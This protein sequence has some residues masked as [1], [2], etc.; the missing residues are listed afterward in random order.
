MDRRTHAAAALAASAIWLLVVG[1]AAE[2]GGATWVFED[3]GLIREAIFT[4][5]DRVKA[6]TSLALRAVVSGEKRGAHWAGPEQGPFFAYLSRHPAPGR[7]PQA[8]PLPDTAIFVGEVT[9]SETQQRGILDASLDFVMPDVEPGYYMLH[10]CNDPCTR[11]IGDMMSTPVTVVENR[12]QALLAGRVQRL[13]RRDMA[14]RFRVED[15]ID[16]LESEN[17]ELELQL[18]A[19]RGEVNTPSKEPA[20]AAPAR[21]S[22]MWAGV[23]W[24]LPGAIVAS[25]ALLA[26]G[27]ARREQRA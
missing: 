12:G 23:G 11:Q 16:D 5:G 8:P 19:L 25:L 13:E 9:F 26:F 22:S 18:K 7:R 2:A 1:G 20:E 3:Q 10:H 14:F 27:R 17:V 24:A 6:S 4:P 21:N 15:L